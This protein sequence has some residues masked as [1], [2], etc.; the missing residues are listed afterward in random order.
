MADHAEVLRGLEFYNGVSYSVLVPNLKGLNAAV[1]I[2]F[3]FV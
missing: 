2:D 3:Y 1:N